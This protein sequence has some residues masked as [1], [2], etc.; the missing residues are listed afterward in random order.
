MKEASNSTPKRSRR[1]SK[2]PRIPGIVAASPR[3]ALA[4][5]AP[6]ATKKTR[7]LESVSVG[8]VTV[9]FT[10]KEQER[11][12]KACDDFDTVSGVPPQTRLMDRVVSQ[13]TSL[14]L[15]DD[16]ETEASVPA[17]VDKIRVITDYLREIG[18][19]TG[20]Q[21]MLAVQMIGVHEAAT[22]SLLFAK[23]A[24]S[25][26][27][28]DSNIL[29]ATRL[30]RLFNEQLEAMAK[31]KGTAGHQKVTVEHVTV[32]EG[33]QAVVGVVT[34]SALPGGSGG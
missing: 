27:L 10:E 24:R 30:M 12:N 34:P 4:C 23:S 14:L 29:R 26:D 17:V 22:K 32:H 7:R 33:G 20:V 18:P 15:W 25:V 5:P 31:L 13:L 8:G 21:T 16:R 2:V 9:P 19:Q 6:P 11:F 1:F 28:Q 3:E